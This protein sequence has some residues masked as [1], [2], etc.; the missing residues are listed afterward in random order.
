MA[1]VLVAY[2]TKYGSTK[3]VAEAV[4]DRLRRAALEVEV[5][6]ASEVRDVSAYSAVVV[7]G[8]LYFFS[9]RR[10]A[11]ALLARNRKALARLP[12]AVFGMG[13]IEDTAEQFE[14]ARGQLDRALAKQPWLTPVSVAVFG[15]RLDPAALRF[16]DNNPA[17]RNMSSVDLRD[18]DAINAWA[19]SL[20]DAFGDGPGAI[21]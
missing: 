1:R 10:H 14:G 15:G 13:P 11:R 12:V 9:W 21:D 3:E 4:A 19:D 16:P 20:P 17:M 5:R 8:A 6:A 7:G 2:A 18:W